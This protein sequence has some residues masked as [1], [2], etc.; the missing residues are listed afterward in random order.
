MYEMTEEIKIQIVIDTLDAR[1]FT[2]NKDRAIWLIKLIR[3]LDNYRER[4][5]KGR[6]KKVNKESE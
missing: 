1:K 2:Y 5:A 4:D 3:A 6:F